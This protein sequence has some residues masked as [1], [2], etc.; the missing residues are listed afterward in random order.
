MLSPKLI[1]NKGITIW[2]LIILWF[3]VSVILNSRSLLIGTLV[4]LLFYIIREN[5]S[6]INR[7]RIYYL[8]ILFS[9][10]IILLACFYKQD[11]SRG[12]VLIYKISSGIFFDSGIYGIGIGNFKSTYLHYQQKYFQSEEKDYSEEAL[13]AD[14]TYYLFNDYFQ[15]V[16]EAGLLGLLIVILF[17]TLIV[18]A[19]V[20]FYKLHKS[21][22]EEI[23]F[24]AVIPL[25]FAALFNHLFEKVAVQ[26]IFCLTFPGII[27]SEFG[28][29][30]KRKMLCLTAYLTFF[31]IFLFNNK[32]QLL[33][34]NSY[35]QLEEAQ[36]LASSGYSLESLDSLEHIKT[37]VRYTTA[38]QLTYGQLLYKI[39]R[40]KDALPFLKNA[41][42]GLPSSDL[43]LLIGLCNK[44]LRA[45]DAAEYYLKS[46]IMMTPNRF[47]P[48]SEL[49]SIYILRNKHI[50]A[51]EVALD[52]LKLPVKIDSQK[53]HKIKSI[54]YKYLTS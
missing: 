8:G 24:I 2:F 41:S 43:Y 20:S 27:Y 10:S 52:I 37:S 5:R 44:N 48:R 54:A 34:R 28:Q 45:Y 6:I 22:A 25:V 51:K 29:R 11:S 19:F 36:I 35:N 49:L 39:H 17:W 23:C 40:F 4:V 50:E 32:N 14:N 33:L 21:L 15:F 13:L 42:A 31:L 7:L 38:Y 3:V 53:V 12:R 16:L 1:F 26:L 30:Q 46:A 18:R 47:S 9:V